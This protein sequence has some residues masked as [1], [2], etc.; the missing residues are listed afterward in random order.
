MPALTV[1]LYPF[2]EL[3]LEAL[4]HCLH[5][6]GGC[7]VQEFPSL[8]P[9]LVSFRGCDWM[10]AGPDRITNHVVARDYMGGVRHAHSPKRRGGYNEL[11]NGG[12]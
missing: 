12:K 7:S 6:L 2:G 10:W 11:Q 5:S 9:H 1:V 4:V 8:V 3:L